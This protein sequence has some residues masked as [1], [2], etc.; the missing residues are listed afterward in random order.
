MY[1]LFSY[2]PGQ[3]PDSGGSRCYHKTPIARIIVKHDGS[4]PGYNDYYDETVFIGATVLTHPINKGKGAALKTAFTTP[5]RSKWYQ[6]LSA[7]Y[8]HS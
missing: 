4:G 2:E 8:C 3:T 7:Q 5:R 1:I 6:H